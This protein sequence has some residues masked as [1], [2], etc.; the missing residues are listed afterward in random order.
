M[1]TLSR[2]EVLDRIAQCGTRHDRCILIKEAAQLVSIDPLARFSQR[3]ADGL[4]DQVMPIRQQ[5]H[6]EPVE[7]GR[8]LLTMAILRSHSKSLWT[9]RQS[10]A[11]SRSSR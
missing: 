8:W 3:P 4:V 1:L 9:S 6:G 5:N 2:L 11:R 10:G 7:I